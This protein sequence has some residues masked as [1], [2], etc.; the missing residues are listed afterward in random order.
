ME[1]VPTDLADPLDGPDL[2]SWTRSPLIYPV[3][4]DVGLYLVPTDG[5]ATH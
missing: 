4:T 2:H 1:Q 3:P 5:S